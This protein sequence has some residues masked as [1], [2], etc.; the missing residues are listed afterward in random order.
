V[1]GGGGGAAWGGWRGGGW[2]RGGGGGGVTYKLVVK[3]REYLT[4][5]KKPRGGKGG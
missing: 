4:S 2:G 1:G 3:D 5:R